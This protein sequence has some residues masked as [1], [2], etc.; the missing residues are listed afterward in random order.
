M[1]VI[2]AGFGRTGTLSLKA[3][4]EQ[5]GF[6]P[7]LHM[8]DLIREGE[9]AD[10]WRA[11]TDG[12]PVDWHELMEGYE[13]TVDWPGCTF[14]AE[15]MEAFPDAKVLLTVRDPD[16]WYESALRTIYVAQAAMRAGEVEGGTQPPPSAAVMGVIGGLIWDGTFE[17][18]FDDREFAID[19]F[20]RHNEAV[21]AAV[22]ADRLLVHEIGEGWE[23]L[24]RFLEVETPDGPFPRLNDT[25]SFREMVGI[26]AL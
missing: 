22:P 10:L 21:K 1:R 2:G 3:A 25:A 12:R 23:P 6:A 26:P 5:L 24:T 14:Y 7:C 19:V 9:R 18:R 16:A 17:G 11:A 8:V 4:L 13:A 20:E 15:L